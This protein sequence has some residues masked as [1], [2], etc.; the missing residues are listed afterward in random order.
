MFKL[1]SCT[2]IQRIL[3]S[4]GDRVHGDTTGMG[5][6]FTVVHGDEDQIHGNS[7]GMG[8]L[9]AVVPRY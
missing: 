6:N 1:E 8:T 3:R 4:N 5:K 2:V 7:V 9:V